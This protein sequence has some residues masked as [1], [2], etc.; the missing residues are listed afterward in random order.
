M[1]TLLTVGAV[2]SIGFG[3]AAI[4]LGMWIDFRPLTGKE[5]SRD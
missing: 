5:R 2:V 1:W 4:V 3:L